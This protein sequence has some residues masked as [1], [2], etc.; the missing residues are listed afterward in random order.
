MNPICGQKGQNVGHY[1]STNLPAFVQTTQLYTVEHHNVLEWAE[2]H[3]ILYMN[4][5]KGTFILKKKT[6]ELDKGWVFDF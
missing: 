4:K 3:C 5:A 1:F 2:E 6:T